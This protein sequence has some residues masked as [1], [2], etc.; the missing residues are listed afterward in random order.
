MEYC[1][2]CEVKV[3]S[4]CKIEINVVITLSLSLY[5]TCNLT[6][7]TEIKYKTDDEPGSSEDSFSLGHMP[8]VHPSFC[9]GSKGVADGYSIGDG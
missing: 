6:S 2:G 3:K 4:N 8:D 9:S 5:L 1:N 7:K